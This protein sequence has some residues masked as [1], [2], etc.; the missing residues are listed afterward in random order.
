MGFR[1]VSISITLNDLERPQRNTLRYSTY[2][3]PELAVYER[4]EIDPYKKIVPGL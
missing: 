1:L 3:F 4:T 2:L